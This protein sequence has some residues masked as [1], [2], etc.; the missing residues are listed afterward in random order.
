M[1][2]VPLEFGRRRWHL[3][4]AFYNS[5]SHILATEPFTAWCCHFRNDVISFSEISSQSPTFTRIVTLLPAT[6]RS[7]HRENVVATSQKTERLTGTDRMHGSM[8]PFSLLIRNNGSQRALGSWSLQPQLLYTTG[9][10]TRRQSISRPSET[11]QCTKYSKSLSHVYLQAA[12]LT[13][14]K[15]LDHRLEQRQ[16]QPSELFAINLRNKAVHKLTDLKSQLLSFTSCSFTNKY[17]C[18]KLNF[19]HII[20]TRH[21]TRAK[22]THTPIR[23]TPNASAKYTVHQ[24]RAPNKLIQGNGQWKLLNNR[25]ICAIGTKIYDLSV[26]FASFNTRLSWRVIGSLAYQMSRQSEWT[27]SHNRNVQQHR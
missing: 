15:A 27:N 20:V 24:L 26:I 17:F 10:T 3:R 23:K 19:I 14:T 25:H 22:T 1:Y 4:W 11:S 7:L 12:A 21:R 18:T 2:F 9:P 16:R 6:R 8:W 5:S 13:W